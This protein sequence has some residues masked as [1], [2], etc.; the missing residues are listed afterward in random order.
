MRGTR[1]WTGTASTV[2]C[3]FPNAA[4][5]EVCDKMR[6]GWAPSQ[7]QVSQFDDVVFF[8]STSPFMLTCAGLIVVSLLL[9]N[10]WMCFLSALVSLVFAAG[11][12]GEWVFEWNGTVHKGAIA[13]GCMAP[14]YLLIAVFLFAF[15]ACLVVALKRRREV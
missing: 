8:F 12:A 4:F 3:L 7:G 6:P 14:P 11:R 2:L 13:E 5:A 1:H 10:R 15:G 9:R